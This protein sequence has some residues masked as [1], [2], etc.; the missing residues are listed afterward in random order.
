MPACNPSRVLFA[1]SKRETCEVVEYAKNTQSPTAVRIIVEPRERPA[2]AK[3]L[4]CP[5]IAVSIKT[6][7][8]SAMS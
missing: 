7:V 1:P 6:K 5:T 2:K 4:T 8:G 3:S